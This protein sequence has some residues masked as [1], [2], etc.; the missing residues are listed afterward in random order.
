V[1]IDAIGRLEEIRARVASDGRVKV[2]ELADEFGVSEMTIRR[3][4]DVL[5]EQG[6]VRRVRGGATPLGP[7]LFAER[8][9]RQA[10]AKDRIAAKLVGLV[11]DARAIGIDA[12]STLQRLAG[13]LDDARDLTIVTNGPECFAALQDNPGVTPLLTGG[14]LD[15]RTGSLVGPLA[16]RSARD[17]ALDVLFVSA[18]AVDAG[19]GTFEATLEEAEVKVAL[20]AVS[21]RV[22]LAVDHSKL[23]GQAA[24]AR[25]LALDRIDVLV[26]DLAPTDDRLATYREAGV[27]VR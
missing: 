13:R 24:V 1:S 20:A 10:R 2:A 22:V 7:Q 12:S 25:C 5:A 9:G 16:T 18:A 21:G 15:R 11:G 17:L 19:A 6:L 3:D 14:R 4:L 27:D 8:F 23:G 26:T